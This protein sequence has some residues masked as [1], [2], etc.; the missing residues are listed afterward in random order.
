MPITPEY[1]RVLLPPTHS[2]QLH[3]ASAEWIS[4]CP[5][6]LCEGPHELLHLL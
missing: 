4:L 2:G 6:G 5:L 1:P 3:W